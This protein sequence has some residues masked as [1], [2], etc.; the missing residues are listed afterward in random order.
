MHV[1]KTPRGLQRISFVDQNDKTV[2]LEQTT[3][4]DYANPTFDEA[5]SSFVLLGQQD[6]P[7]MLNMAQVAEL[8][9]YLQTWLQEGAFDPSCRRLRP[10]SSPSKRVGHRARRGS[11]MQDR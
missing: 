6:A 2:T 8:V 1:T 7:A 4:C 5:G 3:G 10:A 11:V 9:E